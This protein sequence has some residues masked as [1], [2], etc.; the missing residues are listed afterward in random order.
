VGAPGTGDNLQLITI[1]ADRPG[2]NVVGRDGPDTY[3]D[4]SR[5][6]TRLEPAVLPA[7]AL[8]TTAPPRCSFKQ[9]WDEAIK[10]GAPEDAVANIHLRLD[11][12]TFT[13]EGTPHSYRFDKDCAPLP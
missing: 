2:W 12:Y 6:L 11:A 4:W 5:G 7:V 13:I 9:L 10:L 1:R 8:P 3:Y